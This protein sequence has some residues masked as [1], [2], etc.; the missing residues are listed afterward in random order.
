M[1]KYCIGIFISAVLCQFQCM[2]NKS[3]FR[4]K[5]LIY[6][7][8]SDSGYVSH[9][10]SFIDFHKDT[11]I[12]IG[13]PFDLFEND[14]ASTKNVNPDTLNARYLLPNVYPYSDVPFQFER[15]NQIIYIKYLW[16]GK[17]VKKTY[18]NISKEDSVQTSS[19]DF[20]CYANSL[21]EW[22]ITKYLGRDT[23][24]LVASRRIKCW[25]FVEE[26]P[27]LFENKRSKIIY[28]DKKSL[29][30]IQITSI[31]CRRDRKEASVLSKETFKDK[32]DS[33]LSRPWSS[34]TKKWNYSKCWK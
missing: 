24:L 23:T 21:D 34:S 32:I 28:L 33:V 15:D 12:R 2:S 1:R 27:Y 22:V 6:N 29:L 7:T 11:I 20:L 31:Y 10:T 5:I 8:E 18:F 9:N 19:F 30:P 17:T 3:F 26:Y 14:N 4:D 16:E 25:I 13:Y